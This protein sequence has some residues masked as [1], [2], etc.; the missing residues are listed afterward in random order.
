VSGAV[1]TTGTRGD[2]RIEE[3]SGP[4]R[5]A[6]GQVT[7]SRRIRINSVSG[8][9]D[10]ALAKNSDV[11]VESKTVSG[12]IRAFFPG[13]I[14]KGFVGESLD[15]RVG[16]GTASIVLAAVSGGITITPEQ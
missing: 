13:D 14:R 9:I 12:G 3:V 2:V 10:V 16:A 7:G 6:L 4:V 1:T 8:S 11:R 5:A 15:A